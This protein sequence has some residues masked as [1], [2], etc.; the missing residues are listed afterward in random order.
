MSLLEDF[1]TEVANAIRKRKNKTGL[2]EAQDFAEEIESIPQDITG[3]FQ[4]KSVNITSSSATTVTPDTGYDGLSK[5][6]ITPKTQTKTIN[7][8][9]SAAT[10]IIPDSGNVGLS[11]VTVTPTLQAKSQTITS[12]GTVT[13]TPDSGNAGLSSVV[14][15]TNINTASNLTFQR[16]YGQKMAHDATK[17]YTVPA[18]KQ[19]AMIIC[20]MN[21]KYNTPTGVLTCTTSKGS[22]S[23][24]ADNIYDVGTEFRGRHMIFKLTNTTGSAATITL[25]MDWETANGYGDYG[26]D[27]TVVY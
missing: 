25:K 16:T 13:F 27:I 23:L 12:N 8:T 4:E 17:S 22:I 14:V 10:D 15:T 9:T 2:I 5:V 24:Q 18:G 20:C 26:T 21:I 7:I 1:L 3:V 11:K 19:Y 6:T